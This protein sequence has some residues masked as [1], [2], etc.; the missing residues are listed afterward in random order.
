MG[1][2]PTP[3]SPDSWVEER[4]AE[5]DGIADGTEKVRAL[6]NLA[7]E[8]LPSRS[9]VLK[10]A[11][12][13]AQAIQDESSRREALSAIAPQLSDGGE[14]LV[15]Q[16]SSDQLS[17]VLDLVEV[18][19]T[20]VQKVQ[21]LSTTI[22]RLSLGLLPKALQFITQATIQDEL[23][24][25][26]A[27]SNLAPYLLTEQFTEALNLCQPAS[28]SPDSTPNNRVS[29]N[30]EVYRAEAVTNLLPYLKTLE[31]YETAR[32]IIDTSITHPIYRAQA[33]KVFATE[34]TTERIVGIVENTPKPIFESSKV[35]SES[36]PTQRFSD[37]VDSIWKMLQGLSGD[38]Y[39]STRAT[40]L[41]QLIPAMS[42]SQ[43]NTVEAKLLS[44]ISP[45]YYQTVPLAFWWKWYCKLHNDRPL[46][47]EVL[48]LWFVS[49]TY[50]LTAQR[51][52]IGYIAQVFSTIETRRQLNHPIHPD[53]DTQKTKSVIAG[54]NRTLAG[55]KFLIRLNLSRNHLYSQVLIRS[56]ASI[57]KAV[58]LAKQ[59]E[60]PFKRAE[61]WVEIACHSSN[62]EHHYTALQ[63]I[64]RLPNTYLQSQYLQRLIPHL[65]PSQQLE[66]ARVA[67]AISQ[68]YHSTQALVALA[69]KFPQFRRP[70]AE[71][72]AR[73]LQDIVQSVEQLSLLA[74]EMFSL[75]PDI[76]G[77]LEDRHPP[78]E[79]KAPSNEQ[80]TDAHADADWS[81]II[82]RKRLLVA[83]APHL[84]MRIN[85]EV[86]RA[87]ITDTSGQLWRRAL[88]LL[89]RG[90]R[91]ALSKGTLQNE[92][93]Q[94]EDK[95]NLK[96]EVNALALLL[97]MR[98]LE[99]PMA[100]G[101]LGG[102]G[103]GKSYIMH[104]MQQHMTQV[105][106]RKVDLATEA[107]HPNP[108]HEKLSPYVGHI[109]QIKFDAWTFAK[110]DLWAS[111][112]QTIFFEL[113]RQI[114][115]EQQLAQVLA[116]EFD[117]EEEAKA[118]KAKVLWAPRLIDLGL[119]EVSNETASD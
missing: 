22:P 98:D 112:M 81:T 6:V 85:R 7:S 113:N 66:A 99:P 42:I 19:E 3:I 51:K 37:V 72:A 115:L 101:I 21:I 38:D 117:N 87:G 45:F 50:H 79:A 96:D 75:L 76:I 4:L 80:Q 31:Q 84:P 25:V 61:A 26:E 108:N 94:D 86:E 105:R 54:E 12:D 102:W 63:S 67:K 93:L 83:L 48:D 97:L 92:S 18:A 43:V 64:S 24:R 88:Y 14:K 32:N 29:L 73:N 90:Y 9:E 78:T 49:L 103:G 58:V 10:Q 30:R 107:W 1:N 5:I 65:H 34:L 62:S 39:I 77:I 2:A 74:V 116:G 100:V 111:L 91:D 40:I 52:D 68:P 11:L 16:Y 55:D 57:D 27:L 23:L 41:C 104:L 20:D 82:E 47:P 28:D 36:N 110:S 70:D 114:S 44:S 109:Y 33:L 56:R 60:S 69:C 89:A 71:N 15:A 59:I 8:M 53:V 106:S 119:I 118:A 17:G 35:T 95:L 46:K 13:A